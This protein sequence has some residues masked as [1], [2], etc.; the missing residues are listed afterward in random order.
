MW[1]IRIARVKEKNIASGLG[2]RDIKSV[3]SFIM[4]KM[5]HETLGEYGVTV[6]PMS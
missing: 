4:W 6:L 2:E 5:E 3:S 1:F